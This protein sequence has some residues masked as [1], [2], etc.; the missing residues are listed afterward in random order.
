M[1]F[2]DLILKVVITHG[3]EGGITIVCLR[4]NMFRLIID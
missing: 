1:E 2:L 4:M 3:M